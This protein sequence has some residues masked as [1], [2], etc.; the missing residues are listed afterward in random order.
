MQLYFIN[1]YNYIFVLD[2]KSFVNIIKVI[3]YNK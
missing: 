2:K 1:L 3:I